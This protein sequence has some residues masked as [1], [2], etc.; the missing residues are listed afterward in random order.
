MV[1]NI[2]FL[3]FLLFS[4][5]KS[6]HDAVNTWI[7][8]SFFILITINAHPIH[9]FLCRLVAGR[10]GQWLYHSS[11]Q[12]CE[13]LQISYDFLCRSWYTQELNG[14]FYGFWYSSWYYYYYYYWNPFWWLPPCP[15]WAWQAQWDWSW[16]YN[17]FTG[18]ATLTFGFET[19]TQVVYLSTSNT[20]DVIYKKIA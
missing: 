6:I 7:N 10:P 8:C 1:V 4:M 3:S 18:C 2:T 5:C 11:D 13:G 9:S 15:C 12:T 20:S 17:W 19:T 16:S 14:R